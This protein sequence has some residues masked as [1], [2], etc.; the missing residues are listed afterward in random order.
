MI[1]F[2]VLS[3]FL[4]L[5]VLLFADPKFP[6]VG[7]A[8]AAAVFAICAFTSEFRHRKRPSVLILLGVFT[9]FCGFEVWRQQTWYNALPPG[10]NLKWESYKRLFR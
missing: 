10:Y 8:A 3:V 9:L 7:S 1:I 5:V 6:D 4:E 2:L